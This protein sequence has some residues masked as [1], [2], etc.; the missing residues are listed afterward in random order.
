MQLI[1]LQ[2]KLQAL[3]LSLKQRTDFTVLLQEITDRVSM[4]R[5]EA[6]AADEEELAEVIGQISAYFDTVSE[7]R[8]ALNAEGLGVIRDCIVIF[9][10]AIGDAAPGV[11]SLNRQQLRIWNARYQALMAQMEPIFE[12]IIPEP[13]TEDGAEPEPVAEKTDGDYIP[14]IHKTEDDTEKDKTVPL[15]RS[16]DDSLNA[17]IEIGNQKESFVAFRAAEGSVERRDDEDVIEASAPQEPEE[18]SPVRATDADGI[19]LYDPSAHMGG[20]DVVIS[21]EEIRSVREFIERDEPEAESIEPDAEVAEEPEPEFVEP[22]VEAAEEPEPEPKFIEPDVEPTPQFIS[23]AEEPEVEAPEPVEI[24]QERPLFRRKSDRSF[25]SSI[26]LEEIQKLK[27]K[28]FE[29]QEKQE[30]LSSTVNDMLGDI[31]AAK[32]EPGQRE[33]AEPDEDLSVE[34]LEDI[35]FI[36]RK[37]G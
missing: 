11:G 29:L 27:Q 31:K 7:G 5:K 14:S 24:I 4:L 33:V 21:D 20:R 36:G 10:D 12:E 37:K 16:S 25:Q 15:R 28:I 19:P 13:V 32:S 22:D 35:I 9:K 18:A 1:S 3:E 30:M 2:K 26:Q 6:A 23:P 8:L 34:D 17:G